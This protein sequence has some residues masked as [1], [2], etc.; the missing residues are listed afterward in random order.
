MAGKYDFGYEVYHGSTVEWALETVH[1]NS[2]VLEFGPFNGN[3]TKHLKENLFCQVDI[4][5]LDYE[6]GR[7]ASK[8]ARDALIGEKE[9][10]I[11]S[12]FWEKHYAGR[13]YDYIVFLDVIEHLVNT[14]DVLR[15]VRPFLK[16]NGKVLLS[17]PNVSYN[18]V[19]INL[20]NNR[21]PY[22][23]RGLLDCTHLRFFAYESILALGEKLHYG[24]SMCALQLPIADSETGT[25]YQMVPEQVAHYLQQREFANVYQYLVTLKQEKTESE[26]PKLEN[27]DNRVLICAYVASC[28]GET[29]SEEKKAWAYTQAGTNL[30]AEL[31]VSSFGVI[32]RI[33]LD[34][35]E[36]PCYLKNVSIVAQTA[37]GEKKEL[38]VCGSNGE[39]IDNAFVFPTD[40]PQFYV[41]AHCQAYQF[42]R[43]SCELVCY[44]REEVLLLHSLHLW[45]Q[46]RYRQVCSNWEDSQQ[47]LAREQAE[48]QQAKQQL[49]QEQVKHQQTLQRLSQ[50]HTEH[51][52]T[53]Q[54][55]VKEQADKQQVEQQLKLVQEDLKLILDLKEQCEGELYQIKNSKSWRIIQR[56]RRWKN[57]ILRK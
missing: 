57:L 16:P 18:G 6:A 45:N 12:F 31:D 29:Y 30:Y 14:E 41:S 35:M 23:E 13:Q 34:P 53:Y 20:F 26:R 5:E 19:L 50:E 55:L 1:P 54:R 11:E 48:H 21:F 10:N 44:T 51:Q 28:E 42:I 33:R 24:V 2:F 8:F 43:F 47:R 37:D 15:R 56:I 36:C 9:G 17:I 4:V 3:L 52:Q 49:S 46:Q 38:L 32:Q 27:V 25:A 22:T 7:A 40:D 39:Q